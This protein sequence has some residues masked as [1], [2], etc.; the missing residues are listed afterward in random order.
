MTKQQPP[1]KP[2][3]KRKT[4]ASWGLPDRRK[5]ACASCESRVGKKLLYTVWGTPRQ[6]KACG[7]KAIAAWN[8]AI[9]EYTLL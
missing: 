6:C 1:E 2:K 9:K 5:A 4:R 7:S 3:R 8:Q